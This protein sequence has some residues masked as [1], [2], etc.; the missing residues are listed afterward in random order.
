MFKILTYLLFTFKFDKTHMK[1]ND[2]T[3]TTTTPLFRTTQVSRY[4]KIK[5]L[6]YTKKQAVNGS[7]PAEP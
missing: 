3:T 7:Q 2:F 5:N 1:I 6:D 4:Q